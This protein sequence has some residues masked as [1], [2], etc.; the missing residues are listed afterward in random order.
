[1]LKLKCKDIY[2]SGEVSYSTETRD[3]SEAFRS[4]TE[5]SIEKWIGAFSLHCKK[6]TNTEFAEPLGLEPVSLVTKN[7]MFNVK[8]MLIKWRQMDG[9]RLARR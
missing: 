9:H 7:D 6:G 1:M 5:I 3:E 4:R 2:R 8:T